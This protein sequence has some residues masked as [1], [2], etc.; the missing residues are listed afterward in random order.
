M[1]YMGKTTVIF[2]RLK[3]HLPQNLLFFRK[4][5]MSQVE[6]T[7]QTFMLVLDFMVN[8]HRRKMTL[9]VY[10]GRE[11]QIIL[12]MPNCSTSECK[13]YGFSSGLI[14]TIN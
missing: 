12:L 10:W 1:K 3:F 7:I 8:L 14:E 2:G 6:Q 4:K 9:S 13:F 11:D 5:L